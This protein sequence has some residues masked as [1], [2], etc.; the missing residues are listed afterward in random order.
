[1]LL[2]Y[3][4]VIPAQL[5]TWILVVC[6]DQTQLLRLCLTMRLMRVMQVILLMPQD[7]HQNLMVSYL[8]RDGMAK[9]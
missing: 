8:K 5:T 2:D 7:A 9:K 4:L 1:M 6:L 3:R